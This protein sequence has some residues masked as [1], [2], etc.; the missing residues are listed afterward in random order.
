MENFRQADEDY[1]LFDLGYSGFSITWCNNYI[2]P[3]ST[4]AR[5]DRALASKDW[6]GYYL[7]A[8]VLHLST[9]TSDHSPILLILGSQTQSRPAGPRRFRFE[10]GWCLFGESK[11]VVQQAWYKLCIVDPV[12][13]HLNANFT[14]EDVKRSL[15]SMATTKAPGPDGMPALFFQHFWDI[16]GFVRWC[17][18][19]LIMRSHLM[20]SILDFLPA[21]APSRR[22]LLTLSLTKSI[23]KWQIGSQDFYQKQG[24][25]NNKRKIHWLLWDTLCKAKEDGGLGLR[26][27]YFPNTDF[28]SAEIGCKPSFTG[29]SLISVRDLVNKGTKWTLRNEK[30]INVWKQRWVNHAHTGMLITPMSEE[31]KSLKIADLIDSEIGVRKVG[32]R[33]ALFY[34]IDSDSILSM[35]LTRLD[36]PDIAE[37]SFGKKGEFTVK[38][39]YNLQRVLITEQRDVASNSIP[40]NFNSKGFGKSKSHAK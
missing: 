15:F 39:A 33:R 21:L 22:K 11:E 32:F 10:E 20:E 27:M 25:E 24:S 23:P 9:N 13:D 3:H 34:P 14:K 2:S 29:R 28:L 6:K 30:C 1:G 35:P 16:V 18:K 36:N 40:N 7:D 26:K 5:L 4:R 31:F 17:S 37:W 12:V 8:K 38:T 19:F